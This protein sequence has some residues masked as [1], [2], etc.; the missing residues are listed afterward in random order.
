MSTSTTQYTQKHQ[1]AQQGDGTQRRSR[2]ERN[3]LAAGAAVALAAVATF[4]AVSSGFGSTGSSGKSGAPVGVPGHVSVTV[5]SPTSN[6]VIASNR[7]LVR[8]TVVPANADVQIQ[9][10]PAAVGDGVFTGTATLHGGKTTIDV[11]GSYP[12]AA[13]AATSIVIARQPSSQQPATVRV[14]QASPAVIVGP[15]GGDSAVYSG[16]GATSCGGE[17]SVGPDTTCPFAEDV[18]AAYESHGPGVVDAYSPVTNQTYAMSCSSGSEVVC[19]GGNNASVFFPAATAGGYS[20]SQQEYA[21]PSSDVYRGGTSCGDDL[22]V[23]PNTTCAFA[24]NV[25][26][27]F[28]SQGAGVVEAYSPVTH[29]TYS[30]TCVSGSTVQCTGGNDASVYFP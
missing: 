8:G 9:G 7:V 21:N 4:A 29:R 23:G 25:R 19:T 3:I 10:T 27:A 11:V 1:S 6:S 15:A 5:T 13:P 14:I 16:T 12:D 2:H 28:E 30:M 22:W 24:E 18:R 26:S 20:P 17:L